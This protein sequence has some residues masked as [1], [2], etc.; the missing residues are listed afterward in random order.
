LQRPTRRDLIRCLVTAP[1]A[2]CAARAAQQGPRVVRITARKWRF[3]P[4]TITVPRGLPIVL[5]VTSSDGHHGFAAPG[6]GLHADLAP[7]APARLSFT[8]TTSGTFPFRCD[9]F[10]GEGHEEMT[11]AIVVAR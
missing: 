11:G 8:A 9:V 6:L 5:E 1:L 2:G 7:G 10:C 4:E 3:E